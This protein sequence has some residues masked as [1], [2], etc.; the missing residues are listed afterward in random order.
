MKKIL[1]I[2]S[3]GYIGKKLK[4][5]LSKKYILI[6]PTRKQGFDIK[7]KQQIKKYLTQEVDYVVNL[8]GQQNVKKREMTDVIYNGNKNILEISNKL[9]KKFT[10]I[11]ISTSLV[12]GYSKKYLKEN[13]KKNPSNYY[14]KIKYE[15]EKNYMKTNQNYLILRLCNIYGGKMKSGIIDLIIQSI[16][17]KKNFYFDNEKTFKNFIYID[18]VVNIIEI[19]I[20][21]NVKNKIYNI[22]NQNLSF[23]NLLK[24]FKKFTNN[25]IIFYNKNISLKQTLSQ[26]ID[27]KLIKNV[28]KNYKFKSMQ[29]YL[30]DEIKS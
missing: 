21:K 13:S 18:D 6:C 8:S 1:L 11:Y 28:M 29:N 3:T 16:K 26:K 27:S 2:G 9:K 22:G 30:R 24:I 5:K 14:G 12:Y 23:M 25:Q 10:L 4:L 20:R 15:I 17:Y 19:L 7:K